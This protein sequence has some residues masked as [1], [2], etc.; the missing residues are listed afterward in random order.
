MMHF[1][2]IMHSIRKDSNREYHLLLPPPFIPNLSTNPLDYL[3]F[4]QTF[5]PNILVQY[6]DNKKTITMKPDNL[7]I[8]R[9][10]Y[11]TPFRVKILNTTHCTSANGLSFA[12]DELENNLGNPVSF[13][14]CQRITQIYKDPDESK[15][16]LNTELP[17]NPKLAKLLEGINN[18][19]FIENVAETNYQDFVQRMLVSI[20][21]LSQVVFEI[22]ITKKLP[23]C[24]KTMLNYMIFNAITSKCHYK[25]LLAYN[26]AMSNENHAAQ[27][28]MRYYAINQKT[29]QLEVAVNLLK[30]VLHLPS[31]SDCIQALVRF[32]NAVVDSLAD[33]EVG[34][35]DILP[36]ICCAMAQDISFGSHCVSFLNYLADIW[37]KSGLYDEITYVLITCSSAATHL[38]YYK[39]PE[40]PAPAPPQPSATAPPKKDDATSKTIEMLEDLLNSI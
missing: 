33:K 26:K 8:S 27:R 20:G 21:Q 37:P 31:P 29:D 15:K 38:A 9:D 35:D 25:I 12:I 10:G 2:K 22:P 13:P 36:A 6:K 23:T 14:F 19:I 18:A 34:A 28:N 40:H 7:L 1:Q 11:E 5:E 24:V 17:K 30:N 39:P 16:F 32:Y 3:F 4:I